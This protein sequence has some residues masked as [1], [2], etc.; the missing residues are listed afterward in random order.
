MKVIKC[1]RCGDIYPLKTPNDTIQI[2]NQSRTDLCEKCMNELELWLSNKDTNELSNKSEQL[3]KALDKACE[4]LE[5]SIGFGEIYA[6]G[7]VHTNCK[8]RTKEEWK[9]WLLEDEAE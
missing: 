2:N 6:E 1:D 8:H 5:K 7:E 3:E 4:Q 9:E